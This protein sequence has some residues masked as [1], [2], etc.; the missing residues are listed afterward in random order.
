[1]CS[2]AKSD[3]VKM[4]AASLSLRG[5]S[6]GIECNYESDGPGAPSLWDPPTNHKSPSP[7]T[8]GGFPLKLN[9]K[10]FFVDKGQTPRQLEGVAVFVHLIILSLFVLTVTHTLLVNFSEMYFLML[11]PLFSVVN[12]DLAIYS[13]R[14]HLGHGHLSTVGH[15]GWS[16]VLPLIPPCFSD[17]FQTCTS[18]NKS[19]N[20]WQVM[21]VFSFFP[22]D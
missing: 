15:H 22:H 2:I 8:G 13:V 16:Q 17:E 19:V 7:V 6:P 21:T 3:L 4:G 11:V 5:S 10:P 1:M 14:C 9:Q 12:T 18:K 20:R